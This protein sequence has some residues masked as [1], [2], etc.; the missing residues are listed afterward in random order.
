M[1][2]GGDEE[3]RIQVI[4]VG[5]TLI[6]CA[7]EIAERWRRIGEWYTGYRYTRGYTHMRWWWYRGTRK[8]TNQGG[9]T[10]MRS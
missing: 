7:A 8:Q 6:D 9:E 1:V 10:E 3:E 4:C 5:E 2:D